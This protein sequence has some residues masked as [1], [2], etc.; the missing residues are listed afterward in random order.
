MKSKEQG[1]CNEGSLK[2]TRLF[3]LLIPPS[4]VGGGNGRRQVEKD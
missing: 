2:G 1:K 4:F 3:G